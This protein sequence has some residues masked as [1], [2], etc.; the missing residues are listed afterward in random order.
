[1]ALDGLIEAGWPQTLSV[2]ATTAAKATATATAATV[3]PGPKKG[4]PRQNC[5]IIFLTEY[6]S[7]NPQKHIS[8]V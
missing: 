4:Q 7:E 1:M 2:R 5:N 3:I 8:K 6:A